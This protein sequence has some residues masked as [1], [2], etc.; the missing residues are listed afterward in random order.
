[1]RNVEPAHFGMWVKTSGR[2]CCGGCAPVAAD[3]LGKI[4]RPLACGLRGRHRGLSRPCMPPPFLRLPPRLLRRQ[5]PSKGVQREV[6]SLPPANFREQRGV[7]C[8]R[9]PRQL[10]ASSGAHRHPP[11]P[12]PRTWQ[13]LSAAP[14]PA[15][16][17][18]REASRASKR[19]PSLHHLRRWVPDEA[20]APIG[21]LRR[22][23]S[24]AW[25]ARIPGSGSSA[26]N[27]QDA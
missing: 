12:P 1:M 26:S 10:A 24:A 4:V 18:H 16:P 14:A 2:R 13:P 27:T 6:D 21:A 17:C 9:L 3:A 19:R 7:R 22:G 25:R 8:D 15:S 11:P 20:A 5:A 23:W